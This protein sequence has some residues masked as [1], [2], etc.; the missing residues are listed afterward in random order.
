[1]KRMFVISALIAILLLAG[2]QQEADLAQNVIAKFRDYKVTM[3]D[4]DDPHPLALIN[5][6]KAKSR[7]LWYMIYE[8]AL[9]QGYS[10]QEDLNTVVTT[11]I[12]EHT[13]SLLLSQEV[14]HREALTDLM[15][16]IYEQYKDE[17]I[18]N[19]SYQF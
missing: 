19:G 2:C 15:G 12:K 16:S 11:Y 4:I 6:E 13:P 7:I 10:P 1:M 17:V 18:W 14:D 3:D 5:K 8:H 9:Q